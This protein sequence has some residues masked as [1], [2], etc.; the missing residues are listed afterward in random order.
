MRDCK[1]LIVGL[2]LLLPSV[3]IVCLMTVSYAARGAG[4][5]ALAVKD[6]FIAAGTE[7]TKEGLADVS[8]LL[9]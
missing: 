1:C 6:T 9:W 8:V 5:S 4:V 2:L 3:V 7:S